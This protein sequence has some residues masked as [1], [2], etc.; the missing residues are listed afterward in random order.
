MMNR[1]QITRRPRAAANYL[2]EQLAVGRAGFSLPALM[3]ATG[4]SGT[5]AHFQLLRLGRRVVRISPKFFLIVTPEYLTAGAPP[6]HQWLDD[7]FQWLRRP[8]YV[9]LLSA[10][11][12]HGVSPQALQVTQVMTDA[13]RRPIEVGRLRVCFFSKRNLSST[14]TQQ[15][16][17]AFAPLWVSTPA[18]TVF[19]LVRYA[20]RIGGLGRVVESF[21]P[22]LRLIAPGELRA[23]LAT[24]HET[25]T[26]QRLGYALEQL[27]KADL[28]SV[29]ESWLDGKLRLTPLA[30]SRGQAAK[31]R[32]IARWKILDNSGEFTSR[33][34]PL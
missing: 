34:Q 23:V 21:K 13:P 2:D 17:G 24:E 16:A 33:R 32:H 29:V 12:Q 10:A 26:A 1:N 18:S 9:G 27:G 6:P 28:A 22:L 15:V 25:A 20:P 19:D 31:G 11:A 4:L 5:A 8:Y 3:A 14:A 30:P 7:Y